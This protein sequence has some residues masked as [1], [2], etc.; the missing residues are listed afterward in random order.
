[1]DLKWWSVNSYKSYTLFLL[2]RKDFLKLE[3]EG[4]IITKGF[5]LSL[6]LLVRERLLKVGDVRCIII[7]KKVSSAFIWFVIDLFNL[8]KH[9]FLRFASLGGSQCNMLKLL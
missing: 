4:V 6:F 2:V 5:N 8:S 3:I 7:S 1:M 9:P